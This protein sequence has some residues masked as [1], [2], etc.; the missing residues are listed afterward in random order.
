MFV[1][2]KGKEVRLKDELAKR[3]KEIF[4]C[5]PSEFDIELYISIGLKDKS[6]PD[7]IDDYSIE[8]IEKALE[9]SLIAEFALYED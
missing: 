3:Y 1:N 8:D 6:F 9:K 5:D 4:M 2:V 7:T